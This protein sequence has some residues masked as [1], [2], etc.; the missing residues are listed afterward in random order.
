MDNYEYTE[1]NRLEKP[2]KYMYTPYLGAKFVSSYFSNRLKHLKRFQKNYKATDDQSVDLYFYNEAK[3][4]FNNLLKKEL[5]DLDDKDVLRTVSLSNINIEI[6]NLLSFKIKDDI[7][8]ELLLSSLVYTQIN[9]KKY[10]LVKEWLD[11]LVQRFEVTKKL[12]IR[13]PEDFRKGEGAIDNVRLYWLFALSLSLHHADTQSVKY[14]ST[15]LKVS[16]LLC[17]LEDDA[18]VDKIPLHG[19]S[20]IIQ[21][22]MFCV[23]LISDKIEGAG[24]DY[25]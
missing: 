12:H 20:M 3:N 1:A 21:V 6:E 10:K 19:L 11:R 7:D 2:H 8:T 22:E 15:L 24:I 13:Y 17:S 4:I 9:H 23:R 5:F 18:L 16:D 25:N 14:L